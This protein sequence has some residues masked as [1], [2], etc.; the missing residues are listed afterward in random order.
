[1]SPE[2]LEGTIPQSRE[3]SKGLEFSRKDERDITYDSIKSELERGDVVYATSNPAIFNT[4]HGE[5]NTEVH[6]FRNGNPQQGCVQVSVC[7]PKGLQIQS[8]KP[9][10]GM[11][12][13]K[14]GT[15]VED[16]TIDQ[17]IQNQIDMAKRKFSAREFS[18]EPFTMHRY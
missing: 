14:S 16:Q 7:I 8:Y 15:H 1:M 4:E 5:E 6:Y 17:I 3:Y 9:W 18:Y 12:V 10:L 2:N 13:F 11:H